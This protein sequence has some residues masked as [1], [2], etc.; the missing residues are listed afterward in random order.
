MTPGKPRSSSPPPTPLH[1]E[2]AVCGT[3]I[4]GARRALYCSARCRAR[5]HR[6]RHKEELRKRFRDLE[7]AVAQLEALVGGSD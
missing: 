7:K 5:L 6:R 2:C 3:T 4:D 1:K